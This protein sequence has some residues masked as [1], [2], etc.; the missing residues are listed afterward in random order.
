MSTP[1]IRS[2]VYSCSH[3]LVNGSNADRNQSARIFDPSLNLVSNI[4]RSANE[5]HAGRPAPLNSDNGSD[6]T[7]GG[8]SGLNPSSI[9]FLETGLR[10]VEFQSAYPNTTFYDTFDGANRSNFYSQKAGKSGGMC[11]LSGGPESYTSAPTQNNC[12]GQ[13]TSVDRANYLR[14]LN[15][16]YR[17]Q[18]GMY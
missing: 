3:P 9:I 11:Q 8:F 16:V 12:L 10:Q 18:Q 5:N 6:N 17:Q 15:S 14:A 7:L 1:S 4:Y 13:P 2:S